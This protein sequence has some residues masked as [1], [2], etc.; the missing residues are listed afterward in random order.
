MGVI[1][2][3]ILGGFSGKV[4]NVVGSSWKGIATL[5]SLPLSVANPN[6]AAQIVQRTRMTNVVAFAKGILTEIIK[7]LCDRFA[8]GQSGFNLFVQRNIAIFDDALPGDPS[9]LILSEG[10]VTA[11]DTLAGVA[12]AGDDQLNPSWTDNTGTG[13][14]LD[15]DIAFIVAQCRETGEVVVQAETERADGGAVT[16]MQFTQPI[17]IGNNIDMW[18]SF[19]RADGTQVSNTSY[20]TLVVIA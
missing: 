6:T 13:N 3:G 9:D 1:R 18:A 11:F 15:N 12:N 19:R 8:S 7:P 5:K 2:R 16:P 17:A 10:N 20:V 4:A 14:A